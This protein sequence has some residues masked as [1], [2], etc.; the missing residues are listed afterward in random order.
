MLFFS[1]TLHNIPEG[2]VLGVA[3]ASVYYNSTTLISAILLT[4]GIAI[5]NFP[6]GAAISLPLAR[7]G[8]SPRK[9]FVFGVLSGIVE[10]IF[11]VIGA[12]IVLKIKFIL[13]LIMLFTS[14]AMIYVIIIE[15]IPESQK[16]K[17]EGLMA[18]LNMIGFAI[19]MFLDLFLA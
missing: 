11:S 17:K 10:P 1:I 12:L 16:N 18:L 9:A 5:Q 2:L 4:V 8:L 6:E 15:L 19:M 14:G 7:E 13:P 3:F